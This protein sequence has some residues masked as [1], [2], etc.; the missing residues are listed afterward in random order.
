MMKAGS[1]MGWRLI[2]HR[3]GRGGG[4]VLGAGPGD[5][6]GLRL[7]ADLDAWLACREDPDEK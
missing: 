6:S 5:G 1:G 4:L 3:G 2:V 7:L